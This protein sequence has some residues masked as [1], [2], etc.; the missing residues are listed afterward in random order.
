NQALAGRDLIAGRN[1]H[2]NN[3][4][5]HRRSDA[6]PSVSLAR[7]SAAARFARIEHLDGQRASI[8]EQLILRVERN[9]VTAA[10]DEHG[11]FARLERPEREFAFDRFR[12]LSP[13]SKA[14]AVYRELPGASADDDLVFQRSISSRPETSHELRDRK[15]TRLNSSH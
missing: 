11:I 9:G 1:E 2:A 13:V 10:F 14:R 8:D 15:S 6:L 5:R 7:A 4:S 3:L 12:A